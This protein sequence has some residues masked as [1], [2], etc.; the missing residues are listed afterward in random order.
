MPDYKW[1]VALQS[2]TGFVLNTDQ[3]D[4]G[5]L[6]FTT[7]NLDDSRVKIRSVNYGGGRNRELDSL[8]PA[9]ATIVFDNRD[10]LFNPN[11]TSSPYYGSIFPG[12]QI[13]LSYNDGVNSFPVFYGQTVSWS[14]DFD[15]N[16]DATATV[17]AK[18]TLGSLAGVL[19][20][21]TFA[22]QESS[23]ARFARICTL[24]GLNDAQ[25]VY[26]TGSSILAAE[27]IEG[28]A[29]QL[30][31]D[32]VFQEQGYVTV[33]SYGRIFFEGRNTLQAPEL[34]TYIFANNEPLT[35]GFV[36]PYTNLEMVYSD[37]S[38]INSVTT[39]SALGTAVSTNSASVTQYGKVSKSYD[40]SYSTFVE[41]QSFGQFITYTFGDP[42]FRPLELTVS[43]DNLL[44]NNAEAYFVG[45]REYG[46]LARVVFDPPGAGDVIDSTYVVSSWSHSSTP[47]SYTLTVGFEPL[48]FQNVFRL[49]E[50][51]FFYSG[52]L[53]SGILAF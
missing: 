50:Y 32:V 4:T 29:L 16:G 38:I 36:T 40:T 19:I 17:S 23:G 24:A 20:P 41:Q 42:Q 5:Q 33:D 3:L 21:S 37:D 47:A 53:D 1:E 28:D 2:P 13:V 48:T 45:L 8:P 51:S 9:T 7:I 25:F 12:K 26:N 43:I 35:S 34:V 22:S 11:N 14:F 15:V 10:G 52:Q 46:F 31:Q 49:D 6:G 39:T 18:D 27:S 30:V 44:A